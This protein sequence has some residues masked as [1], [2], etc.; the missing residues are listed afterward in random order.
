MF[1]YSTCAHA[2]EGS[3]VGA[4]RCMNARVLGALLL[5]DM[6][7]LQSAADLAYIKVSSES[8]HLRLGFR[9]RL[10]RGERYKAQNTCAGPV[11]GG[12]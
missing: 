2:H 5:Q 11:V 7:A 1:T 6:S 12:L 9:H 3:N 10:S 4:R 8:G